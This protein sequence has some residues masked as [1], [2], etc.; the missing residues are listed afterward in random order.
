MFENLLSKDSNDSNV[1]L[2]DS[3][4]VS[5]HS[6]LNSTHVKSNRR[7]FSPQKRLRKLNAQGIGNHCFVVDDE[8]PETK[9]KCIVCTT[10]S[11]KGKWSIASNSIHT[12]KKHLDSKKHLKSVEEFIN[13]PDLHNQQINTNTDNN[14]DSNNES[15][16]LID[17]DIDYDTDLLENINIEAFDSEL[18]QLYNV[19]NK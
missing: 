14:I 16:E 4:D 5:A 11:T 1:S 18:T 15:N 19:W 12:I 7:V 2:S 13:S 17:F 3:T 8:E 6:Q 10:A 9:L